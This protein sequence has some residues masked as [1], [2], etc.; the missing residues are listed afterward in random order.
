MKVDGITV[1]VTKADCLRLVKH[2]P[3]PDVA[4]RPGTER[5]SDGEPIV[6]PDLHGRP[7]LDLP[8]SVDIP[9]EV[10]L[11]ERYGLP[12]DDS[13]KGDVRVGTVRIELDSGR[14][15]FNGQP[16]TGPDEAELRARCAELLDS[17]AD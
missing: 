16:L 5:D 9:I 12:A 4:Y 7:Q 10:D 6:P 1:T 11:D 3:A 17:P 13:F 14:A 8:E 15:T 2:Q